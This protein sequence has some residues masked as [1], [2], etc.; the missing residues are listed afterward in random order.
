MCK[1]RKGRPEH[2][3]LGAALPVAGGTTVAVSRRV[4]Q[5]GENS[6]CYSHQIQ[7]DYQAAH[8]VKHV[9]LEDTLEVERDLFT[10]T[11]ISPP[12]AA[13]RSTCLYAPITQSEYRSI[14]ASVH[15]SRCKS[16]CLWLLSPI[17]RFRWYLFK[18]LLYS[19]P[20]SS[21]YN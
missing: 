21:S 11:C 16:I 14:S 2:A 15:L 5:T 3:C 19:N 17:Y 20:P 6:K 7:L 8:K 13:A 1:S 10:I 12:I 18:D 9:L 4:Y